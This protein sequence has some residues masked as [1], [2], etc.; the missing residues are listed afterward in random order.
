MSVGRKK[1]SEA[2][3]QREKAAAVRSAERDLLQRRVKN[4]KRRAACEANDERWLR[5]YLPDVFYHDFTSDQRAIIRDVGTCLEYGTSKCIAAPRGD[6]KSSICRYLILKYAL[7]RQIRFGLVVSATGPKADEALRAVKAQLRRRQGLLAADYPVECDVA[8]YVGPASG[9][10]HNV[11]VGGRRVHAEWAATRLILPTFIDSEPVGPIIMAMGWESEQ[12]Q[13]CNVLDQRPDFTCLDDLDNRESLAAV[14]GSVA[15]KIEEI[16]DKSIGGLG[17]P[18][19][20]LGQV[21]LCT[22]TSTRSAAARYSDRTI[23][24][25]WSGIRLPRI[26]RWPDNPDLWE[27]YIELRKS[28]HREPLDPADPSSPARDPHGREA[29]FLL[30]Q[31]FEAMHRGAALSNEHDYIKDLLPDG[32]PTHLSALQK[33]YDFISDR[34]L[35]AFE[36]EHQNAPPP[37]ENELSKVGITRALVESRLSGFERGELPPDCKLVAGIDLGKHSCYWT[38]GAFR[39][40]GIGCIVNYGVAEV[41]GTEQTEHTEVIQRALF[42]TLSEWRESMRTNP[43]RDGDGNPVELSGVLVDAGYFPDAAYEVVR[44]FGEPYRASKGSGGFQHGQPSATRRVGNHWFA[45]PQA[46]NVWLYSLDADHWKRD[47]H[48]RFIAEPRDAE[49]R[50][51]PGSLTLFVPQ[52]SRDHHTFSAH[53]LSEEWVTEFT[54][55]KGERSRW[56]RHSGNNHFFDATALMLAA[57]EMA[58]AGIFGPAKQPAWRAQVMPR[59]TTPDGRPYLLTER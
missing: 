22:I 57:A 52:G 41:L 44:R 39:E 17:G 25:A 24:P 31:N 9:R 30:E 48:N 36:T 58:G 26:K 34:G 38:V 14:D 47:V 8:A 35:P 33:C 42:R 50:P 49:N 40:G 11:T 21:Y 15:G 16:I 54:P 6:G 18:G 2:Q 53:I 55:N 32:T 13:G 1:R 19:R 7:C 27:Q 4:P 5:T 10:C 12:L 51:N 45:T 3:R 56:L 59:F 46:G 20:R 43:F 23:K 28:G 37:S 29:H